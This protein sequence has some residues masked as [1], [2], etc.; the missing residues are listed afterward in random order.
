MSDPRV[1]RIMVKEILLRRQLHTFSIIVNSNKL[2]PLAWDIAASSVEFFTLLRPFIRTNPT[3]LQEW[4]HNAVRPF[5]WDRLVLEGSFDASRPRF[6]HLSSTIL[7]LTSYTGPVSEVL[8]CNGLKKSLRALSISGALEVRLPFLNDLQCSEICSTGLSALAPN[9]TR[10]YLPGFVQPL[11][12]GV[13]PETLLI[14]HL[15]D[16]FDWP[17]T[18]E[19]LPAGLQVL[20]LCNSYTRPLDRLPRNLQT[21]TI[22][23]A[24][25]DHL[26]LGARLG[27]Q[28]PLDRLP[29]SLSRLKFWLS[30]GYSQPLTHLPPSLSHL[31]LYRCSKC[32]GSSKEIEFICPPALEHLVWGLPIDQFIRKWAARVAQVTGL[33]SVRFFH[34][35][36]NLG[37][38]DHGALRTFPSDCAVWLD[39]TPEPGKKKKISDDPP[40]VILWRGARIVKEPIPTVDPWMSRNGPWSPEP[41]MIPAR[42]SDIGDCNDVTLF[43]DDCYCHDRELSTV[44]RQ[45]TTV[46][47]L[48]VP[49]WPS[50]HDPIL[51]DTFRSLVCLTITNASQAVRLEQLCMPHLANLTLGVAYPH[52]FHGAEFPSLRHLVLPK[53]YDNPIESFPPRLLTL[54]CGQRFR[55]DLSCAPSSLFRVRVS[56]FYPLHKLPPSVTQL[57]IRSLGSSCVPHPELPSFV[58]TVE[59]YSSDDGSI[60]R[61]RMPLVRQRKTPVKRNRSEMSTG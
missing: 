59:I 14:L 52:P 2:A 33:R 11:L 4:S 51:T 3:T 53:M 35:T 16:S 12:P 55:Q 49:R 40:S 23:S 24:C 17:L 34:P 15:C 54:D 28:H 46:E 22:Y 29:P 13:L 8:K 38:D 44:L 36:L 20:S 43:S 6:R 5:L 57:Q 37:A 47:R 10:L 27:F 26:P 48:S 50:V 56:S 39:Q 41:V 7:N 30:P 31:F 61:L 45:C 32:P 58:R 19:N 25:H 1:L 21:L 60:I 18:E 42:H 9:L